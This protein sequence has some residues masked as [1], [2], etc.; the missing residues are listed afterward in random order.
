MEGHPPYMSKMW[1]VAVCTNSKEI[2]HIFG[3]LGGNLGAA[4]CMFKTQKYHEYS[5]NL[6]FKHENPCSRLKIPLTTNPPNVSRTLQPLNRRVR[7]VAKLVLP[8]RR[9]PRL[10]AERP[11]AWESTR[12][13]EDG[14]S[15]PLKSA[16]PWACRRGAT[17]YTCWRPGKVYVC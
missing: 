15:E 9:P 13:T 12:E 3:N 11:E 6:L 1:R 2:Y 4:T 14:Q 17:V 16:G 5:K 10:H 7:K 8:L